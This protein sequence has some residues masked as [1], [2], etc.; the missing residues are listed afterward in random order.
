MALTGWSS[1]GRPRGSRYAAIVPEA[2]DF[3][4]NRDV[5]CGM[6]FWDGESRASTAWFC[7][8]QK[9]AALASGTRVHS[10][11]QPA[12]AGPSSPRFDCRFSTG[13][14]EEQKAPPVSAKA[15]KHAS[16]EGTAGAA[17]APQ[18]AEGVAQRREEAPALVMVGGTGRNSGGGLRSCSQFDELFGRIDNRY[19]TDQLTHRVL[20]WFVRQPPR[21]AGRRERRCC[22]PLLESRSAPFDAPLRLGGVSIGATRQTVMQCSSRLRSRRCGLAAR[23]WPTPVMAVQRGRGRHTVAREGAEPMRCRITTL[24]MFDGEAEDAMRFYTSLFETGGSN[25]SSATR[26]ASKA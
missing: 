3:A 18:S 19:P 23:P 17:R 16:A 26:P 22:P 25:G 15:N 13:R 1:R 6:R 21:G 9:A 8:F 10:A 7:R 12:L 4:F 14:A 20:E 11:L 24:L 2:S 5:V